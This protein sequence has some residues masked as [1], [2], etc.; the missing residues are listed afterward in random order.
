MPLAA[1]G[2]CANK[3]R[4]GHQQDLLNFSV[5]P[6]LKRHGGSQREIK[7]CTPLSHMFNSKGKK[8]HQRR[9]TF[10]RSDVEKWHAAVARSTLTT[11]NYKNM[12]VS[13]H[14]R[15]ERCRKTLTDT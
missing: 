7:D 11:E 15:R 12:T 5:F 2:Q 10:G 3:S 6:M 13:G 14:S 4:K 8:T 1:I 9:T